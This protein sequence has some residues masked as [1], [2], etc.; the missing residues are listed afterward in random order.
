MNEVC[1]LVEKLTSGRQIPSLA[2]IL[3]DTDIYLALWHLSC[4][5]YEV[6]K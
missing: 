4:P 6:G 2:L 5:L 3:N 1:A